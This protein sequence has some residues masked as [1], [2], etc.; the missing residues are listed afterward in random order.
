VVTEISQEPKDKYNDLIVL[1]GGDMRGRE[2]G[3][4]GGKERERERERGR[5]TEKHTESQRWQRRSAG[6][7]AEARVGYST[8]WKRLLSAPA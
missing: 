1:C 3:R 8:M 2:G 6:C 4:E 7:S 5:D